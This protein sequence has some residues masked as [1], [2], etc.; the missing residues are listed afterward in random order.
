MAFAPIP[1]NVQRKT[2]VEFSE[3]SL[4]IVGMI[5]APLSLWRG[6]LRT[7]IVLWTIAMV[8]RGVGWVKPMALKPLF[9]GMLLVGWPLG[10]VVSN[11]LLAML[12]YGVVLPIGLLLRVRRGDVIGRRLD[13][14]RASYWTPIPK[15][16]D[17]REYLRQF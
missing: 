7:A 17:P 8:V 11:L 5:A 9:L 2:L 1:W 13:P 6:H 10:W 3:A 12:F 14:S 16:R 4:M 15:V